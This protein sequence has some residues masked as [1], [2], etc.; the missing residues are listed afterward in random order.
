MSKLASRR[1][2]NLVYYTGD[3]HAN[4][5]KI[6][7]FIAEQGLTSDDTIVILG[8]AMFNFYGTRIDRRQKAEVNRRGVNILCVHG[9]HD[10]RPE[11]IET[12][13]TKEFCGGKVYYE[14]DFPYIMFA[15]D[16]EVYNLDGRKS[17]VVGGA[18][19][20]DKDERILRGIPWWSDEQPSD[21]IKK[22]VEDKLESLHW[23]IDQVLT[24]TC[25]IAYQ[26]VEAF[27]SHIDQSKVDRS[28]EE[29]LDTIENRTHYNRWLCG[30]FHID[31]VIDKVRFVM[32]DFII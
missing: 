1:D 19:T 2:D 18:Y 23:Q 17:I 14:E 25:P 20:V 24:H 31:K 12:Y 8:D 28:T 26:P 21:E 15:I 7:S 6:K 22:A 9:N 32:N 30:H 5:V 29:W 4:F 10:R 27:I 16:S 13:T 11:T 3:T